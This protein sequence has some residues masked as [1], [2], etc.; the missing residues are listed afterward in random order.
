MFLAPGLI[1]IAIG[2]TIAVYSMWQIA[3]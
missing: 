2:V 3:G 1:K